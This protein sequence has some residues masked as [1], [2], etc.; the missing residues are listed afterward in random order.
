MIG[1]EIRSAQPQ[2]EDFLW[3]MLYY[4]ARMAEDGAT[5]AE[6]AKT[7]PALAKYVRGWGR[8]ADYGVIA[9]THA[10]DQPIGAV[11]ARL[12]I[13][14]ERT[15]GYIDDRTPELAAAVLPAYHG[16]GVGTALLQEFIARAPRHYPAVALN[17]RADNPAFRLYQRVGFV[18]VSEIT[19]RV[20]TKSY[21]MLLDFRTA[22]A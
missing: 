10:G 6:P 7:D 3:T 13:S 11:W 12:L 1:I 21:N 22:G 4:A 2:D 15:A 14:G 9:R 17:V 19:N 18:V 8:P 16:R 20:G 5:S